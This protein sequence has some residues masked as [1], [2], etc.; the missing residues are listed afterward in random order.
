MTLALVRKILRDIRVPLLVVALL[1]AAFQCL[2]VKITQ[3]VTAQLLPLFLGLASAQKISPDQVE[4]I[5]FEG[6]GKVM[7]TL[8]GG[9]NIALNRAMDMLSVGYV[10]PTM[11]MLFCIWAIGRAAG[12]IVG[13]IDRGTMELLLA[14]PLPRSR[15]ILA[16]FLV[17]VVVIPALCLSMW[18]G[19]WLGS[20]VVGPIEVSAKELEVL[21]FKVTVDAETLKIDPAAFGPAL[22]NVGALLFAISGYTIWLSARGR[23][24]SRTLGVAVL[25]T[26]LQ[27]LINVLGQ[28]WDPVALLRPF[29]VFFYYQPQQIVLKHQWSVDLGTAWNDGQPW[30]SVNVLV[31]LFLVGAVGYIMAWRTFTR[32]DLPAP[33]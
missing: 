25:I 31:L 24:R 18:S 12:A 11:Q 23:F 13:E 30:L 15:V 14:Q 9:E 27:F 5:L 32:R 4:K 21:P 2:W 1:L 8:M 33:L 29:T 6:P 17:D 7:R 20:F 22:W 26:L 19:T 3:R 10:H 28:L 16:N